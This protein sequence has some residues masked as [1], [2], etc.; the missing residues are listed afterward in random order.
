MMVTD[1]I[2][3]FIRKYPGLMLAFSAGQTV[4]AVLYL[5]MIFYDNRTMLLLRSS[6]EKR[7]EAEFSSEM[8]QMELAAEAE[9]LTDGQKRLIL[10]GKAEAAVGNLAETGYDEGLKRTVTEALHGISRHLLES[11]TAE[12][13]LSAEERFFLHLFGGR[14]TEEAYKMYVPVFEETE[15]LSEREDG[16]EKH[17]R[18]TVIYPGEKEVERLANR[19]FG[20]SGILTEKT[21]MGDRKRLF[22]CKNA[23]AVMDAA[24]NY[25]LEAGIFLPIGEEKYTAA[26]CT[27]LAQRF[28]EEVYPKKIIRRLSLVRETEDIG[29]GEAVFGS[30]DGS[31]VTVRISKSS[32]KM[33][34]LRA[35]P[36]VEREGMFR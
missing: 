2:K 8:H 31:T 35:V 21:E 25:P 3:R 15:A 6:A 36:S 11:P 16:K 14:E 4:L 5:W 27:A 7:A 1:K 32:G 29:Y 13:L 20:V 26:E 28:L 24:E 34:F 18:F 22:S 19:L 12:E 23:Y 17:H 9:D 30:E 33:I 10:Y